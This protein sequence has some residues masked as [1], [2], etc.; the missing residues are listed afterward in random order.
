VRRNASRGDDVHR[1]GELRAGSRGDTD[2]YVVGDLFRRH[3]GSELVRQRS[4]AGGDAVQPRFGVWESAGGH[5]VGGTDC[6]GYKFR[7]RQ[8]HVQQHLGGGSERGGLRGNEHVQHRDCSRRELHDFSVIYPCG[9]RRAGRGADAYGQCARF[10]ADDF[11]EWHGICAF[12][13]DRGNAERDGDSG[14]VCELHGADGDAGGDAAGFDGAVELHGSAVAGDVHGVADIAGV[15]DDEPGGYG[16]R[17]HER[18][19]LRAAAAAGGKPKLA[20]G[21]YRGFVWR[22]RSGL[23]SARQDAGKGAAGMAD[24]RLGLVDD[25]RMRRQQGGRRLVGKS[26]HAGRN[27]HADADRAKLHLPEQPNPNSDRP[28]KT[29]EVRL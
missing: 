17:K 6:D 20:R 5:T 8:P 22:V 28:V 19:D 21:R 14:G 26:R 7:Q 12:Q 4:G 13:P 16:E 11:A 1:F 18:A 24:L 15:G 29:E 10:A 25:E 2:G 3:S 23:P 9:R 27:V